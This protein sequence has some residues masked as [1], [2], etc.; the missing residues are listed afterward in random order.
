TIAPDLVERTLATPGPALAVEPRLIWLGGAPRWSRGLLSV[1]CAGGEMYSTLAPR[2]VADHIARCLP[3][4]CGQPSAPRPH[5]LPPPRGA[6]PRGLVGA[7]PGARDGLGLTLLGQRANRQD[8]KNAKYLRCTDDSFDAL[9]KR[10][11]VEVD[12]QSERLS[13][14]LQVRQHLSQVN[15]EQALSRFQLDDEATAN[16]QIE[17][18]VP[19]GNLLG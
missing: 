2:W 4:S 12:Q 10:P 3:P 9:A 14:R 19:D 6:P 1:S 7:P 8:A 11:D 5:A 18:S 13:R 15:G 16:Q 17:P